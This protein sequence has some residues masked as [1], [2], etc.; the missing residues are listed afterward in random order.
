LAKYILNTQEDDLDF[1]LLGITSPENQYQISS[2]INDY[3]KINLRLEDYVPFSLKEGKVFKFS[4]F[5]YLDEDL[6][7]EYF[8]I[9]NTSNFEE[10]NV[11]TYA[12]ND[13]FSGMDVDES[14]RLIKEL[15]KTQYFLILKGEDLH[16]YQY[17][18][19]DTLKTIPEII[20]IQSI[21]AKDLPSKRNLIF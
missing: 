5:Q 16:Q 12:A 10:P 19:I 17:K 9:P 4:L 15:P 20:Q 3:L 18:I 2:L 13:L 6:G 1:V 11:N 14:V 21:E 8:F 7:L